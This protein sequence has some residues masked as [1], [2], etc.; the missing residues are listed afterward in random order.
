LS[1]VVFLPEAGENSGSLITADFAYQSNRP[2]YTVPNDIFAPT[3]F[4][5]HQ[6]ISDSK[7]KILLDFKVFFD[8]NFKKFGIQNKIHSQNLD[9]PAEQHKIISLLTS[10]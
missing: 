1:D 7:A 3:S 9:L 4:G 8:H 10:H 2:V 5:V 6:L